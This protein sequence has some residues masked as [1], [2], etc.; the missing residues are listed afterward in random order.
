MYEILK[1]K[2]IYFALNIEFF[3]IDI[4]TLISLE[5]LKI[6]HVYDVHIYVHD[7]LARYI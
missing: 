1:Y 3:G 5:Y 2:N 6:V 7:G 4:S